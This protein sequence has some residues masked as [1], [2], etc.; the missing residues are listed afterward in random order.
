M[1]DGVPRLLE[2]LE[3]ADVLIVQ[4]GPDGSGTPDEPI[5]KIPQLIGLSLQK[6]EC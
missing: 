4:I 6:Q 3:V 5:I 1:R 2:V